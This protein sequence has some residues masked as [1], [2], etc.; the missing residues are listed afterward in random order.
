MESDVANQKVREIGDDRA[1]KR[2][3]STKAVVLNDSPLLANHGRAHEKLA[4]NADVFGTLPRPSVA[5]RR[6]GP[7]RQPIYCSTVSTGCMFLR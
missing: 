2:T 4:P 3:L 5:K 7:L 1:T 6:F